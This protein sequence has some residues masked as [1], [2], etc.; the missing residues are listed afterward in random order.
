MKHTL[1]LSAFALA[2]CGLSALAQAQST[3]RHPG[4][5]PHYVFELEPELVLAP[6]EPPKLHT[7]DGFGAGV[8]GTIEVAP[9]GFIPKLNDSVGVG[10]GFEYLH[11]DTD[12][13]GG[14]TQFAVGPGPTR[15]CVDTSGGGAAGYLYIPVVLQWNFWLHRKWSVFG[16]P[17]VAFYYHRPG[18]VDFSPFGIEAGGRYHFSNAVTLTARVGFPTVSLGVSFL[19]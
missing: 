11:Y 1:A 19:L 6:F 15:V 10:F 9:G 18:G 2:T 13:R 16:E 12:A 14:C 4:D 17:G 8:R 7:R 5:R 3:I